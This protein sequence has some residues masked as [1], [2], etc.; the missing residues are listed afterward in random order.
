MNNKNIRSAYM[1]L[2]MA[3]V[4]IGL[5]MAYESSGATRANCCRSLPTRRPCTGSAGTA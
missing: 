2:V 5:G 1:G 4:L 3:A